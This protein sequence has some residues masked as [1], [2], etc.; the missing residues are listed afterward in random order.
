MEI[1]KTKGIIEAGSKR[2]KDNNKGEAETTCLLITE[3]HDLSI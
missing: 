3:T 2:S 1:K